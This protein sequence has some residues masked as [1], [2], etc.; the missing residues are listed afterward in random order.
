L[1]EWRFRKGKINAAGDSL[2]G[3]I[4]SRTRGEEPEKPCNK[5]REL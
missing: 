5:Q 3:V 4:G 1:L 2:R